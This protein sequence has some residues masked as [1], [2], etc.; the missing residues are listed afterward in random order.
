[1]IFSFIKKRRD[2]MKIDARTKK[3]FDNLKS[4]GI[5]AGIMEINAPY[6]GEK[7][8]QI[9]LNFPNGE[10]FDIKSFCSGSSGNTG[11]LVE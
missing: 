6:A 11:F 10:W 3:L 5:L 8:Q 7:A 4:N 2:K 9:T 1:M